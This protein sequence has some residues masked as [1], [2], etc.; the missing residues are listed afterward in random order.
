[1]A[2]KAILMNKAHFSLEI[3]QSVPCKILLIYDLQE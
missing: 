3:K 1:M 2:M